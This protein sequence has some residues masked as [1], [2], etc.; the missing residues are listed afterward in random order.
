M[1]L[2]DRYLQAVGFWLPKA[3]KQDIVAELSEDISSQM[4]EKEAELSRKLN[5]SEVEAILKQLGSPIV[6]AN[7]Y[8]PQR[9]LIG[10]LLLPIYWVVLKM[11]WL[12][13][14]VP[15]LF[16][17]ICIDSFAPSYRP[18][19][20]GTLIGGT[21]RAV[22]PMAVNTF[23]FVTVAFALIEKY[24][25][26]SGFLEKWDPRK[27]PPVRDPNRIK[28]SSSIA[29]IVGLIAVCVWWIGFM[30]SPVMVD[31]PEVRIILTPAWR[32]FFWSILLLTA[33]GA[34]ASGI[35]LFRPYWTRFRASMR[36]VSDCIGWALCA[37]LC[38]ANIVAE[39][40]VRN[41]PHE[42]TMQIAAAI[43]LWASRSF[44]V[45]VAIGVLTAS[46]DV[47]R[48]IRVKRGPAHFP[49]DW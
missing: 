17:W 14:F 31:R 45:V 23:A 5:E 34:I 43:N 35:N 47:Y 28:R 46:V 49:A 26:K 39:I 19:H 24:H 36:L 38:K 33:A 12:F 21:L 22:W 41:V 8:L 7:R 29:E 20:A 16:V 18:D 25:V 2:I 9:H 1:E 40:S 30:S 4:E 48:I 44:P 42:R 37:W 27:L 11:A 6:V 3:Q 10:P 13:Y 32:Y 15:W